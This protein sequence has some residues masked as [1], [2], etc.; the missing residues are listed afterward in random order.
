M[1]T[2]PGGEGS[3]TLTKACAKGAQA[4]WDGTAFF[5]GGAEAPPLRSAPCGQGLGRGGDHGGKPVA[6]TAL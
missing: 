6:P 2:A 4:E 5:F 1:K 3:A